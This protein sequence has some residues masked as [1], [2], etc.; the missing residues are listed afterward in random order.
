MIL[1]YDK[2]DSRKHTS[3]VVNGGHRPNLRMLKVGK[4]LKDAIVRGWG[5]KTSQ[6]PTMKQLCEQIQIEILV[7]KSEDERKRHSEGISVLD[8]SR[9][10][11]DRSRNSLFGA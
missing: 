3:K 2:Y 4:T 7:R 6:R 11:V 9:F 8:R 1:P 10:L 5:A